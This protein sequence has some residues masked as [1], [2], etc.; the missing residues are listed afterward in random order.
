MNWLQR[1][2]E[3]TAR[4][5]AAARIVI[6]EVT[7]PT[8]R[9]VGSSMLVTPHH[10][11]GRIGRGAIEREAVAA[12]R[13]LIASL[14]PAKGTPAWSRALL[15]FSTGHVLGAPTG[16][17]AMLAIE[18]FGPAEIAALTSR[19]GP[20]H[21]DPLLARRLTAGTAPELIDAATAGSSTWAPASTRLRAA[22][23][24]QLVYAALA[25]GTP[26]IVERL[27]E[28]GLP[29]FVYGTG[30]VARAL[31]RQL[32]ELPFD[33]TWVDGQPSHFPDAVPPGTRMITHSD[34]SEVA[35]QAPAGAFHAIMTASHDLDVAV[36]R[37]VLE[38][39]DFSYLGVIGSRMKRERLLA[40]LKLEGV[41]AGLQ[42][43]V[44]C[45]IGLS[46]I[47]SKQPEVI[48]VSIA[49][50]ALIQLQAGQTGTKR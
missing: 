44:N 1:I 11:E 15:K 24:L 5:G 42:A 8:P 26:A 20:G 40:R 19:L 33:V 37:A 7:G 48:A 27:S 38:R 17:V 9:S 31:V 50:Q 25:D 4:D 45:P 46:Q 43:R 23:E 22:P 29:F 18:A 6:V 32:A 30:L 2:A 12:A 36:S 41:P 35:R 21:G 13:T 49:A 39:G 14:G 34:I 47:R 10:A 28:V 3:L 16:G